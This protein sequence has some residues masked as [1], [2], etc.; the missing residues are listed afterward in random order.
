[1]SCNNYCTSFEPAVN[2]SKKKKQK[3]QW[4]HNAKVLQIAVFW[5]CLMLYL[6]QIIN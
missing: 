2:Y 1:M 5:L 4:I 3:L 6:K